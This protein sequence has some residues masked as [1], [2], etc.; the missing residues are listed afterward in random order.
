MPPAFARASLPLQSNDMTAASRTIRKALASCLL[1]LSG[2][3]A[4]FAAP[5]SLSVEIGQVTSVGLTGFQVGETIRAIFTIDD[6]TPDLRPDIGTGLFEDPDGGFTLEGLTSGVVLDIAGGVRLETDDAGELEFRSPNEPTASNPVVLSSDFDLNAEDD[7]LSNPDDLSTV[8][9]DLVST[10]PITNSVGNG[11]RVSFF[12][13]GLAESASI[14]LAE[15]AEVS[16]A[17]VDAP[18]R[19]PLPPAAALLLGGLGALGLAKRR[20]A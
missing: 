18:A 11:A 16:F 20:R 4:A 6:T 8:L 17:P 14:D 19:I 2:A 15:G 9:A 10:S 3:G 7:F 1:A 13:G 5:V 12:G